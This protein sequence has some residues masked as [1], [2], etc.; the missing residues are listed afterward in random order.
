MPPME[1]FY[2]LDILIL[3]GVATLLIGR[4][5]LNTVSAWVLVCFLGPAEN[6]AQ[7]PKAQQRLST[8]LLVLLAE[9]ATWRINQCKARTYS[10][11][12]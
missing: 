12:V 4:A 11:Q 2:C 8:L 3:I 6:R 9:K 5:L 1:E 7:F 10:D